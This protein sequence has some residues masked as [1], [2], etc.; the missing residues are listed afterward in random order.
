MLG[1]MFF[2]PCDKMP[3]IDFLRREYGSDFSTSDDGSEL[4]VKEPEYPEEDPGFNWEYGSY[5]RSVETWDLLLIYLG[6]LEHFPPCVCLP[7]TEVTVTGEKL[8]SLMNCTITVEP[9]V[10]C[11]N[12]EVRRPY[13]RLRGKPV[14]PEQKKL[15]EDTLDFDWNRMGYDHLANFGNFILDTGELYNNGNTGKYPHI[16]EYI[17]DAVHLAGNFPFLD[18]FIAITEWN[19]IPDYAWESMCEDIEEKI[20]NKSFGKPDEEDTDRIEDHPERW[21]F[22]ENI[23]IG[24]HVFDGNI[25]IVSAGKALSLYKEYDSKYRPEGFVF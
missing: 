5:Y 11:Y 9:D 4:Y 18:L 6:M 3:I 25:E 14:T 16:G 7:T 12:T 19:E 15:M 1:I 20:R 13:Y 2:D 23:V 24:I 22:E 8:S 21:D 17:S 10:A